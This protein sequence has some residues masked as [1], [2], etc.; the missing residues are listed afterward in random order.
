MNLTLH[1][2]EGLP[3]IRSATDEG[4]LINDKLHTGALLVSADNLIENWPLASADELSEELVRP[5]L[6]LKPDLFILGTGSVQVFPDPKIS[7]L[8]LSAGIGMEVMTTPAA[9]RTFNVV[10]S[11]GRNAVAALLPLKPAATGG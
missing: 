7:W 3:Q 8:L 10:M 9:C 5:I 11:E 6:E 4:I 1:H 2:G